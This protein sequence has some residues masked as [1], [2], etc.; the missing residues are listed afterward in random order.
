MTARVLI[1]DDSAAIRHA[2][3]QRF[4]VPEIQI[5][6]EADTVRSA[7]ASALE[8]PLDAVVLD[9]HLPDGNGLT[10]LREVKAAKPDLPVFIHSSDASSLWKERCLAA[11]ADGYFIKGQDILNLLS[12]VRAR[13]LERSGGRAPLAFDQATKVDGQAEDVLASSLPPA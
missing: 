5:L 6:A 10:V 9:L 12:A 4:A 8:L 13:S 1:V 11:G 2:L 7:I 3:R